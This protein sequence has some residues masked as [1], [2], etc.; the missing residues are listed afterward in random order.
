MAL[1]LAGAT[2]AHPVGFSNSDIR[3][4]AEMLPLILQKDLGLNANGSESGI[5]DRAAKSQE[6]DPAL[7]SVS[8][9]GEGGLRVLWSL[10]PEMGLLSV[11]FR[12]LLICPLP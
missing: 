2:T 10:L 9:D 3:R 4:Q 7:T 6:T 11:Q 1:V 5:L 12:D 8:P